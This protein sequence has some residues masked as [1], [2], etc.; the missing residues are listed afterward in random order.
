M[1]GYW[2]FAQIK[3]RTMHAKQTVLLI[4]G[5]GISIYHQGII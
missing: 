3:L 2:V 5:V 4:R 1:R